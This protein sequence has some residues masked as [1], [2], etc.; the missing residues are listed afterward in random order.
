MKDNGTTPKEL[1][2]AL[3]AKL[4]AD[5]EREIPGIEIHDQIGELL[6]EK[7]NGKILNK[8]FETQL[9]AKLSSY[10]GKEVIVYYSNSYSTVDVKVWGTPALPTTNEAIQFYV[11]R[12]GQ[13]ADA[14]KFHTDTDCCHGTA[15]QERNAK[16]K[17]LLED[18][19]TLAKI[20]NAV[21]TV[22]DGWETL[23]D[24]FEFDAP[25]SQVEY[26]AF[27]LTGLKGSRY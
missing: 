12:V 16:R 24:T 8:R 4:I 2:V 18:E 3:R 10:Y 15:A 21:Q 7:W 20:A 26:Y 14:D 23:K 19:K 11:S 5:I 1:I 25:A 27:E 6:K 17:T 13:E 22:K 9:K